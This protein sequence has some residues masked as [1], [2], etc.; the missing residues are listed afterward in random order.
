MELLSVGEDKAECSV[1]G[2]IR[3]TRRGHLPVALASSECS[4]GAYRG[5]P[6]FTAC[7]E[8]DEPREIHTGRSATKETHSFDKGTV[9]HI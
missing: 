8:V 4:V 1:S 7:C 5:T 2:A 6:A 9:D 3:G